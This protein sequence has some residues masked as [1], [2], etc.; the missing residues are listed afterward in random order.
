MR[1]PLPRRSGHWLAAIALAAVALAAALAACQSGE[2]AYADATTEM[3]EMAMEAPPSRVQMAAAPPS[4]GAP[5]SSVPVADTSARRE[6]IRTARVR[7]RADDHAEAVERARQWTTFSGG[8]VGGEASRRSDDRVETTLTLRVPAA[9]FDTLL[10]IVSNLPGRLDERSVSVDDVTRQT[11]DTAARL[12]SRRA[13]EARYLELLGDADTVPEVLAVQQRL[14]AVR[15]EVEAAEASLRALRGE[16]ALS[17]IELTV[18]E[19]SAAGITSGPGFAQ[20]A[21]RAMAGGWDGALELLLVGLALWPLWLL[22]ALAVLALRAFRRR[23]S[24]RVVAR[25][26]ERTPPPSV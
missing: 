1:A 23:R 19:A 5:D 24:V 8:F 6:L 16:V 7:L 15:E 17:T 20:R 25:A 2:S 18:Y 9:R 11:A 21:L 26:P 4:P 3:E 12:R 10:T 22:L 13:A 14:D